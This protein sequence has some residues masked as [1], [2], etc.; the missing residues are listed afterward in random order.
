MSSSGS[1]IEI[2]SLR[3]ELSVAQHRVSELEDNLAAMQQEFD[4]LGMELGELRTENK[5]LKSKPDS[6]ADTRV[7]LTGSFT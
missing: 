2:A 3:E 1:G 5:E 7:H 4:D 6:N